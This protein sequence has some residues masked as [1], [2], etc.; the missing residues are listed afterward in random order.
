MLRWLDWT[1]RV[2]FIA[3]A[4]II[5]WRFYLWWRPAEPSTYLRTDLVNAQQS[6]AFITGFATV[7]LVRFK[8]RS[9][10]ALQPF[11]YVARNPD[12]ANEVTGFCY[13]LYEVSIGYPVLRAALAALESETVDTT[14]LEPP[15]VLSANIVEA[16]NGGD[17][18]SQLRC[19]QINLGPPAREQ[20]DRLGMLQAALDENGQ[21]SSHERHAHAVLT[22]FSPR[23]RKQQEQLHGA[24]LRA[25]EEERTRLADVR[26]PSGLQRWAQAARRSLGA[27]AGTP[28]SIG[29]QTSAGAES[30]LDRA[31]ASASS[32][33]ASTRDP[34]AVN[35][36]KKHL[37]LLLAREQRDSRLS[38]AAAGGYLGSLQLTLSTIGIFSQEK[39]RWF[40]K[41]SQFYLRQDIADVVYGSDF[42]RSV[43]A[44]KGG[45]LSPKRLHVSVP[46]PQLLTIDRYAAVLVAKPTDFRLS[47]DA[48]GDAIDQAMSG[49]LEGQLKRITPQ[50]IRFAKALLTAQLLTLTE[51]GVNEVEIE[52]VRAD[53]A[54]PS[55][56]SDLVRLMQEQ[57]QAGRPA[58]DR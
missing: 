25:L 29:P 31:L 11:S 46:D 32:P 7:P 45:F 57:S 43:S 5:L 9:G 33:Q 34:G 44:T 36:A 56:L 39:G 28:Q 54:V 24:R 55:Q 4:V 41:S 8:T 26:D 52:F 27:A 1:A 17:G 23:L 49:D 6:E 19:D 22:A 10:D 53:D 13:R 16:R 40:W 48:D 35:D 50:A 2:L 30:E 20:R 58:A 15:S 42:A 12:N 37:G 14:A 51:A 47:D 18:A 21:W 38:L 3:M